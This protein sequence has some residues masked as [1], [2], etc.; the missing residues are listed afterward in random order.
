MNGIDFRAVR[1]HFGRAAKTYEAAAALQREVEVRL[2][3]SLV[4]AKTEPQVVLDLGA[5]TGRGSAALKKRWPKAEVVALDAALPMLVAARANQGWL[6][7]FSRVAGDARALP[8]REGAV[9]L[10][11]SNLCLQWCPDLPAVLDEF[12]RVLRP[13]ALLLF[14]TFGPDT[15]RELRAAFATVDDAPHVS[16]FP[17]LPVIGDALL[18][19]GFRDPV[20]DIDTLTTTYADARALMRELKALGA[21]NA[22]SGRPGGLGGRRRIDAAC[23]A[24]EAHRVDGRLPATWEIITAMAFAPEPGQPRRAREGGQIAS[25]DVAKLRGSRVR[26]ET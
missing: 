21:T 11:F 5:G 4:F 8:L 3:E 1:R 25:F 24:Y 23:A 6:R 18:A 15:L 19:A 26:R 20:V 14:S 13:G 7:K 9:D 12:R 17:D 2:L 22:A 16:R 10:L